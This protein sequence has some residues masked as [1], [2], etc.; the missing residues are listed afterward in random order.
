M[1]LGLISFENQGFAQSALHSDF[2]LGLNGRT[3]PIGAQIAASGG[4]AYSFWGDTKTWKYGYARAGLNLMTSA[5]VNRAGI[6]LQVFPISIFGISAGYDTG[7]RNFIPKWLDCNLYECTGRV[8]RKHMRAALVA[9][10]SGFSFMF[11]ARYEEL[12]G[13]NSTSKLVF[14]ETTLVL[15]KRDGES[16][17]TMN[18]VL[19]YQVGER[20]NVGLVSLYTRAL[21]TG[22]YS[23]LYGPIVSH[24]TSPKFNILAGIGL[25][26]S[27]VVH[28]G[29]CGF[30]QLQYNIKPS[31]SVMDLALRNS[32]QNPALDVSESP[33]Q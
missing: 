4:L 30:F 15:A 14:D 9:A 28:S 31:L 12:R 18:P 21:N 5:V 17:F 11:I 19:L 27:P 8:D 22:G 26:T 2:K 33:V 24:S 6:E 7:T 1:I 13:F 25:N 3:Y 23:H 32:Q 10:Y 29:L 16:V 20:T